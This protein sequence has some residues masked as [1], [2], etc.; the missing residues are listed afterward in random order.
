MRLLAMALALLLL[1]I[2]PPT[3]AQAITPILVSN[4]EAKI[5]CSGTMGFGWTTP[6]SNKRVVGSYLFANLV[7]DPARGADITLWSPSYGTAYP[8]PYTGG[9]SSQWASI[10]D[11]HILAQPAGHTGGRQGER[12]RM[13]PAGTGIVIND[14]VQISVNCWGGGTIEIYAVLY[15]VDVE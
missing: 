2:A 13:F 7:T 15:V 9:P 6:L 12:E 8:P 4:G 5:Q 1:A 14:Y 10:N 11:L 3:R